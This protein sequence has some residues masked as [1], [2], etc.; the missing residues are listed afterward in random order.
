MNINSVVST[1][2]Q[3]DLAFWSS[4]QPT[5]SGKRSNKVAGEV[6]D[7][8]IVT[9]DGGTDLPVMGATTGKRKSQGLRQR[10]NKRARLEASEDDSLTPTAK[11][12][13]SAPDETS[14]PTLHLSTANQ[15]VQSPKSGESRKDVNKQA[16]GHPA[17]KSGQKSPGQPSGTVTD[18]GVTTAQDHEATA[19][20][21]NHT[22][23]QRLRDENLALKQQLHCTKDAMQ[24]KILAYVI[25]NYV[26]FGAGLVMRDYFVK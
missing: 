14:K 18:V 2:L 4:S 25:F 8:R 17:K 13:D 9:K 26:W 11:D 16:E 22:E 15:A 20:P 6:Q 24:R 7:S 19:V 23:V 10:S 21:T 12:E 3:S 5:M 1:V